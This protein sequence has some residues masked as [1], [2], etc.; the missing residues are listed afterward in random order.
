MK[1]FINDP[2][3]LVPE[4]LE[5][6]TLAFSDKVRLNG[7]NTVV[8][9]TPKP[10]GKV[11]LVTL[12]GSGHEPGLSGFVGSGMLDVSVAGEIFAAPGAV[13]CIEAIRDACAG[14]ESTLLI[15]L[16]HAGDVLAGNIAMQ[17]VE[18]E[19]L[20]VRMLLT[21]EDISGPQGDRRGLV[22]CVAVYKVA[23][24]AAEKGASLDACVEVA[25]R[26]ANNM[27]TLA[28][29]VRT[30]THPATGQPIFELGDDEME[31]GMGQHGESGTGRMQLK[32]ADETAEIMLDKLL[33]DLR[34]TEGEE[35]LVLLNGAGATTLMELYLVF[36]RVAH[37]L[38]AK[39]IRLVRSAIGEFI[40]TQEQAGFQMM[41][42]RLDRELIEL[43]DAPAQAP[44]FAKP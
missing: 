36:R 22:G 18:R 31:V 38:T 23:G 8:R 16:N 20:K 28:V 29:A 34:V 15:V 35:L 7:T 33:Q 12:G 21:E 5:G 3:N 1:K 41:I 11:R 43:W 19:G 25:Q 6:F 40:T 24:A 17:A 14:G 4:L 10:A 13:K 32:S 42:A 44:F 26:M 9:A 2:K 27:R 30:A 39:R 37:L